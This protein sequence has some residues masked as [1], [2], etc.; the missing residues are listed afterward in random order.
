MKKPVEEITLE[1]RL[2]TGMSEGSYYVS[3][4]GYRKQFIEKLG[5][6]P[7]PGTLNLKLSSAFDVKM[8][9]ELE[10]RSA[11]LIEGFKGEGRTFGPVKCYP[12]TINDE[13]EGAVVLIERTRYDRSV[14]EVIA[15][16]CLRE[17]LK[18][19]DGSKVRV[20]VHL[21]QKR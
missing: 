20:R 3:R 5:F 21:G 14:L 1:G 8:R 17:R 15:P 2:F 7:Y 12:A 4:D 16:V 10:A 18:L 9:G 11:I 13:V 19:R 6:D